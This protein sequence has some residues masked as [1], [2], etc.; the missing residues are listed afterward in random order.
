M[1]SDSM[2]AATVTHRL[3]ER[4]LCFLW[5][6]GF[7][8]VNRS[9]KH[10]HRLR[11]NMNKLTITKTG[12][13]TIVFDLDGTLYDSTGLPKKLVLKELSRF[14][15][16]RIAA[17][18][19]ARKALAGVAFSSEKEFYDRFFSLIAKYSLCSVQ[20]AERWYREQYMPDFVDILR[21]DFRARAGLNE[22]VKNLKCKGFKVVVFSDYG[23]VSQK[24]E[25]IGIKTELFD[26]LLDGPSLGGLKP[27]RESFEKAL[28]AVDAENST[29]LVVGDRDDTDGDGARAAGMQFIRVLKA[30]NA[31]YKSD[32]T[33]YKSNDSGDK[34]HD[35]AN[36][37]ENAVNRNTAEKEDNKSNK[38]TGAP[39]EPSTALSWNELSD[40]LLQIPGC[41]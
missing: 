35:A 40:M 16:L 19:K 26:A 7:F 15:L 2:A 25:A 41:Q 32:N 31:V 10:R 30:D 3:W 37:A 34:H 39:A 9:R 14:A 24:M 28:A 1:R 27:C 18:R 4:K 21:K 23:S 6:N 11:T 13:K 5:K 33:I 36:K 22:M 12:I 29:S 38:T 17:E 8:A 20:K